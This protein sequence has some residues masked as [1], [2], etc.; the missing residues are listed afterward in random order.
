MPTM[1]AGKQ[2]GFPMYYMHLRDKA[3]QPTDF[4]KPTTIIHSYLVFCL[5]L[6]YNTENKTVIKNNNFSKNKK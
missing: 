2:W 1:R 6:K 3:E 4:E 5:F